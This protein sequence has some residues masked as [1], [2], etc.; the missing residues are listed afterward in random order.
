MR[1]LY[2]I[3]LVLLLMTPP[4][5][6]INRKQEYKIHTIVID[7]GHGGHDSGCLGATAKE[8]NISLSVALKVGQMIKDN[9]P[10]VKVIFTREK[11]VF[12]PLH[13][14]AEI[15]NKNK[16]DL[17][18][19]IHCNSGSSKGAYGVETYVMGLHK[20]EEN[21]AVA[22]RENASVLLEEDYKTQY[23]GFDPHS[24]EAN[25]I[26][27]LYQNQFLNQSLEFA[28][29]VQDQVVEY[30][31]RHNRGVR[32]AGFLVLYKTA[33][34]SVLIE[35]GFLTHSAEEKFLLSEKGQNNMATCIFRAFKEY[36]IDTETPSGNISKSGTEKVISEEVPAKEERIEVEKTAGTSEIVET[37]IKTT[38][39]DSTAIFHSD[40]II[41]PE[42]KVLIS[43]PL[44]K[45]SNSTAHQPVFYDSTQNNKSDIFFTIQIGAT[46][47]PEK[48][49]KN[50]NKIMGVH[51]IKSNDG[52]TR[53]IVG[54]FNSL[55]AAR[56][57]QVQLRKQGFNDC[58]LAAYKG[59]FKISIAE[60]ILQLKSK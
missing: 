17:F 23:E 39:A 50:F 57:K 9:F 46:A 42:K 47:Q 1:R 3:V 13:E 22:R 24:A 31:G 43:P 52:L 36:K 27:N 58:F 19:C 30:A 60:A 21:L 54:H 45:T 38:I 56:Q 40:P 55:E 29:N 4:T 8:K 25:I 48:V 44:K 5:F 7:A 12:I 10:D 51:V 18:I 15:A 20:T 37:K 35:T 49:E 6:S 2:Y 26:F 11:D 28:S 34:P 59:D 14:R 32:Q 41:Q 53:Y 16:A 33:M